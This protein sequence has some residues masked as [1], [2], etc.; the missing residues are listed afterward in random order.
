MKAISKKESFPKFL[1]YR[2]GE[3]NSH[4]KFLL[5]P[6]VNGEIVKV[7]PFD[8]QTK[9][10]EHYQEK[11]KFVKIDSDSEFR[12]KFVKV[13]RKDD[14]GKWNLCY[15]ESWRNFNLLNKK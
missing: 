10:R 4:N 6:W 9:G 15:I 8:E 11:F 3:D 5:K 12:K 2:I 7:L 14:D 13:L 1:S